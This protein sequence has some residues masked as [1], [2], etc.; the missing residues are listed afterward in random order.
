MLF[1]YPNLV[2]LMNDRGMN[3]RKLA[4][5]LNISELAAYRRLRGS[6]EWKLPEVMRL[7]QY[8]GTSDTAWLFERN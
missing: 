3:Y 1:V 4:D 8:F 2:R 6:T 7:C 5:I